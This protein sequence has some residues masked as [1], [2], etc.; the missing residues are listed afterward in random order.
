MVIALRAL[1]AA[2]KGAKAPEI[3]QKIGATDYNCIYG[4]FKFNPEDHAVMSGP[5]VIPVPVAQI[6]DGRNQI[7]WP[8][9]VATAKPR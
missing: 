4:R 5:D 8:D 6:Q 1:D 9:K 7:I 2:G 3:A